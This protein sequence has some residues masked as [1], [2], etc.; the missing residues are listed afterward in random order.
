MS[1]G[2]NRAQETLALATS[3]AGLPGQ[4]RQ[5]PLLDHN[6]DKHA[7]VRERVERYLRQQRE[8]MQWF[9]DG[10]EVDQVTQRA[11]SGLYVVISTSHQTIGAIVAPHMGITDEK[12]DSEHPL[13]TGGLSKPCPTIPFGSVTEVLVRPDSFEVVHAGLSPE[14]AAEWARGKNLAP[15]SMRR[16]QFGVPVDRPPAGTRYAGSIPTQEPW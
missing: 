2:T 14:A 12:I 5:E 6:E 1:D 4:L 10:W 13:P 7:D 9:L 8:H 15:P 11:L 3:I 16:Q